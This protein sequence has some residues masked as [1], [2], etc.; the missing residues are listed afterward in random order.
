LLLPIDFNA[1]MKKYRIL[2]LAKY[3][4]PQLC[5]V[6]AARRL[7]RSDRKVSYIFNTL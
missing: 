7:R 2:Y 6:V 4:A 3:V 1:R 5:D